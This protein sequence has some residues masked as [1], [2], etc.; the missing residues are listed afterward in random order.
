MSSCLCIRSSLLCEPEGCCGRDR[1]VVGC[2]TTYAISVSHPQCCELESN[3]WRGVL[4]TTLCDDV[5]QWFAAGRWFSLDIPVSSTNNTDR[6]DITEI[7][8]K[9][10]LN[11]MLCLP[12]LSKPDVEVHRVYEFSYATILKRKR[13]FVFNV[14]N[15]TQITI[16]LHWWSN[17]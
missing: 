9:V 1:M 2:T 12:W 4:D 16:K 5:C 14:V 3:S 15:H 8:V 17:Y 10:A 6:H 13:Y 7:V 11:A